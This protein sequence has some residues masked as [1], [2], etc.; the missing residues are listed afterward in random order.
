[1][2]TQEV[3]YINQTITCSDEHVI[4]VISDKLCTR[5]NVGSTDGD[6]KIRWSN[7]KNHIK[8]KVMNCRVAAHFNDT[9]NNH[10]FNIYSSFDSTLANELEITL[11]DK[12][13]PEPWDS[14]E[15]ITKKL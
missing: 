11:I 7:H 14:I 2:V 9:S 10:K 3:F 5:Q 12:V 1:M 15:T 6:M 4:Y 13:V 8:H